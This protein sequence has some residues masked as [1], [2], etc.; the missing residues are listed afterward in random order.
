MHL[1][2]T[3]AQCTHKILPKLRATEHLFHAWVQCVFECNLSCLEIGTIQ[4]FEWK[5][6]RN[7]YS[8]CN[9]DYFLF[10]IG[11]KQNFVFSN[12]ET[13][14]SYFIQYI[15]KRLLCLL[16]PIF[17][18]RSLYLGANLT[19]CLFP[20]GRS[21]FNRHT[22][23]SIHYFIIS[24]PLYA[25]QQIHAHAVAPQRHSSKNKCIYEL[26]VLTRCNTFY[27]K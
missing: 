6:Q 26:C 16:G 14:A 4:A 11:K 15:S 18:R 5:F 12:F 19:L 1:I 27:V 10:S 24:V 13:I 20:F 25:K 8:I 17:N 23:I 3:A 7:V 2:S 21:V 22:K 9:I